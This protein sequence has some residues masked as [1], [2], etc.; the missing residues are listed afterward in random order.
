[1]DLSNI[2]EHRRSIPDV[3]LDTSRNLTSH[4]QGPEA[5]T[6]IGAALSGVR[7]VLRELRESGLFCQNEIDEALAAD[8]TTITVSEDQLILKWVKMGP[9]AAEI[10]QF[11]VNYSHEA[12]EQRLRAIHGE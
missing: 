8:S 11:I 12:N 9:N 6:L 5:N 1:M 7:E 2:Q 10:R 4:L 3:T